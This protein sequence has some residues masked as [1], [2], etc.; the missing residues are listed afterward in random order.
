MV[1]P[2]VRPSQTVVVTGASSFVGAHLARRFAAEGLSVVATI[3]RP[4]ETYAGVQAERLEGLVGSADLVQLELR[5][6]RGVTALIDRMRPDLWLHH[7]GYATSYASLDYD[8]ALGF[9]TNVAPLTS[10]YSALA[11]SRCGVIVTGSS[12]EYARSDAANREDE[13]CWPESPYGLAK[14]AET[15]RACQ[16]SRRHA[17]A[18]RVARL[19]IPF[20]LFDHPDKLLSQTVAGLRAGRP[21][22]LS[23]CNQARDF[24]GIT[25]VCDAYVALA[26]DLQRT[27]FDVFNICNGEPVRLRDFLLG[28]AARMN[29]DPQ[30]LKFGARPLREGEPA[31]SYGSNE[32]ARRLLDWHPLPL[33]AAIDRDLLA[34]KKKYETAQPPRRLAVAQLPP[35]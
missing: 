35:S 21:I 1:G 17:V 34:N 3:S 9:A 26:R 32:K 11:G 10:L 23:P 2:A 13:A 7:A 30:L 27:R 14:L 22:A 12:A 16:L 4:R 31:I 8:L 25:D 24:T 6:A 19:Y 18:T 29:A 5:D 28:I 33:E 20:G 15:L